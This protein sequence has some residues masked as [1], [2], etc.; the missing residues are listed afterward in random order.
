MQA[1]YPSLHIDQATRDPQAYCEAHS[2]FTFLSWTEINAPDSQYFKNSCL[3]FQIKEVRPF[4][5]AAVL[6][7]MKFTKI[8]YNSFID[9]QDKLHHNIGRKRSLVAIGTHDL[10]TIQGPFIYEGR[11]PQNIKF[12]PLN[13]TKEFTAVEMME[14]YSVSSLKYLKFL[15]L[16]MEM[17]HDGALLLCL[18]D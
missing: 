13:Q 16:S 6:R 9:L 12:R 2:E 8:V 11:E 4:A 18:L 7:G 10:D 5:V 3:S 14:M 17:S 1:R 15:L